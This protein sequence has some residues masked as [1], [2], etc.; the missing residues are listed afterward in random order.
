[1]KKIAIL[2]LLL[3]LSNSVASARITIL[4]SAEPPPDD[5]LFSGDTDE[6]IFWQLG[7]SDEFVQFV[8][9]PDLSIQYFVDMKNDEIVPYRNEVIPEAVAPIVMADRDFN[10][11]FSGLPEAGVGCTFFLLEKK[12]NQEITVE[13]VL[14]NKV[15]PVDVVVPSD[16]YLLVDADEFATC[17]GSIRGDKTVNLS[18]AFNRLPSAYDYLDQYGYD[19]GDGESCLRDAD[20]REINVTQWLDQGCP[21]EIVLNG[22]EACKDWLIIKQ[23]TDYDTVIAEKENVDPDI[24]NVIKQQ[25]EA[26]KKDEEI[27]TTL[28]TMQ[29]GMD[30][31]TYALIGGVVVVFLIAFVGYYMRQRQ[32]VKLGRNFLAKH[33]PKVNLPEVHF[34]KLSKKAEKVYAPE[35][36][37]KEEEWKPVEPEQITPP[38]PEPE[39][40]PEDIVP[41]WDDNFEEVFMEEEEREEF[42]DSEEVD[43]GKEKVI[44]EE[45]EVGGG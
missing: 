8:D 7:S 28:A 6:G 29:A 35:P 36:E 3:L 14:E 11:G 23:R 37:T 15:F 39:S 38:E 30:E 19:C 34:P 40:E 4:F 44:D 33:I 10:I 26:A 42:I 9:V 13:P 22:E 16:Y 41:D 18:I 1:M 31:E 17:R 5:A 12:N 25:E 20:G 43:L 27:L 24:E 2:L 21:A 32:G 45:D